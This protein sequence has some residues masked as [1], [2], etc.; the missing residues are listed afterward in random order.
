MKHLK[1]QQLNAAVDTAT[2]GAWLQGSLQAITRK[3]Y[4]VKSDSKGVY[5]QIN[6][7]TQI[8][9]SPK[10][11][12][13]GTISKQT[14]KGSSI[15]ADPG[16][17]YKSTS[18]CINQVVKV[19]KGKTNSSRDTAVDERLFSLSASLKQLFA[20]DDSTALN[21]SRLQ[22]LTACSMGGTSGCLEQLKS[23]LAASGTDYFE[24]PAIM[25]NARSYDEQSEGAVIAFYDVDEDC[26][27]TVYLDTLNPGSVYDS[28]EGLLQSFVDSENV[29]TDG[30]PGTTETW[31]MSP[32]DSMEEGVETF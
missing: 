10:S 24:F 9:I 22:N 25:F 7:S 14:K 31:M 11:A 15:Q 32:G 18:D 2:M 30:I 13:A 8:V 20:S 28:A 4:N 5:V 21:A 27:V 1:V 12:T 19:L 26:Y 23:G 16:I 29:P 6:S 17:E 3:K